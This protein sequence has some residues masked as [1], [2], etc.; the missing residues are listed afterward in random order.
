M[1]SGMSGW[2]P[3]AAA[4]ALFFYLRK[5]DADAKKAARDRAVAEIKKS[6]KDPFEGAFTTRK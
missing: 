1:K 2:I 6:G 4:G 3:L 5:K